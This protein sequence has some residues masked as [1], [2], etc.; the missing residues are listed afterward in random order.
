[1]MYEEEMMALG[2]VVV[3]AIVLIIVMLILMIS[4]PINLSK[5]KEQ[6]KETNKILMA[7][8]QEQEKLQN[9]IESLKK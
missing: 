5:I 4:I 2:A 6:Q 9:A 8:L 7:I 3:I 1:M